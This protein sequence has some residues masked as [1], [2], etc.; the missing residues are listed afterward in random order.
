M[1]AAG[2]EEVPGEKPVYVGEVLRKGSERERED[3]SKV[4]NRG[5]RQTC[6]E[7]MGCLM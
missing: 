3:K 7:S 4:L 5:G 1:G 6:W 2:A